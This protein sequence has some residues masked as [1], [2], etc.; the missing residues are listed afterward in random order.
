MGSYV[1]NTKKDQLEMLNSI[2]LS[3]IDEL[4]TSI[5]EDVLLKRELKIPKGLSELEVRNKKLGI[6]NCE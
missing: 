2:G 6:R 5:P 4:Y 3:S 1:P